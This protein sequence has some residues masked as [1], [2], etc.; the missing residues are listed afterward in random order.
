[1]AEMK[2]FTFE[3]PTE[4]L[5]FKIND[6]IFYAVPRVGGAFIR[7]IIED[8]TNLSGIGGK[9]VDQLPQESVD[10]IQSYTGKVMAFLDLVMLPESQ[11]RFA[12]RLR[13]IDEPIELTQVHQVY[14]WLISEYSKRPTQPLLS[15]SNGHS[16]TGESLTAGVQVE[17]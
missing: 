2:D 6:D 10:K 11:Q 7:E 12:E 3:I 13:S 16:G 1:M 9:N 4:N 17:G 15:S 8:A 5:K 14:N